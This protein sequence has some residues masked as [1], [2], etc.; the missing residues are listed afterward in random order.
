MGR[1]A[2]YLMGT[3]FVLL[4]MISSNSPSCQACA[5]PALHAC[6]LLH[7]TALPCSSDILHC[8]SANNNI[9]LRRLVAFPGLGPRCRF[10][11]GGQLASTLWGRTTARRRS[12]HKCARRTIL[13]A[14]APSARNLSDV[15]K[16]LCGYAAARVECLYVWCNPH[17]MREYM[18]VWRKMK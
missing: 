13:W 11:Y 15:L 18:H 10:G 3:S 9:A 1:I 16:E 7:C 5:N 6:F 12:A 17:H 2:H 4:V 14:I 8:F